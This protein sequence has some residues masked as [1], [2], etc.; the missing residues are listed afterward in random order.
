MSPSCFGEPGLNGAPTIL[1]ISSSSRAIVL[2][3]IAG[4][5]RQHVAV[6][7]DAA[8]L[9]ARQH[10]DERPLER[11]V[12]R[13]HMLGGEARLQRPPEAHDHIGVLGGVFRRLVDC[14]PRKADEVA[15]RARD[16]GERDRLVAETFA[17]RVR[18][19]RGRPPVASVERIG[20]QHRVVDRRDGHAAMGED[21]HAE[22]DVVADLE[23]ARR[24][25]QRLQEPR[26]RPPPAI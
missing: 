19:C 11:L 6:D 26:S 15:A 21:L 8:P 16:L 20:N 24:L 18:P 9:H 17:P 2:G 3:E 7:G 23:D 13:R 12:D 25:H 22:L 10:R 4:E 5:P 1:L 14:D